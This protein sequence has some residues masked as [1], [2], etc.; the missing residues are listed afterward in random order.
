LRKK[1]ER[2]LNFKKSKYINNQILFGLKLQNVDI[3]TRVPPKM[4]STVF[5]KLT[6]YLLKRLARWTFQT[7]HWGR[8]R[9]SPGLIIEGTPI[10]SL[11]HTGQYRGGGG[12]RGWDGQK[13]EVGIVTLDIVALL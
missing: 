1:A 4:Y 5:L 13:P 10:F 8:V 7:F 6:A 11:M 2:Y 9:N 3:E 12:R